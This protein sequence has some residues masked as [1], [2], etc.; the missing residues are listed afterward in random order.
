VAKE[1][2][3]APRSVAPVA[4]QELPLLLLVDDSE[5][6]LSLERAALGGTYRR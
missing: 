2:S 1:R 5:A 3:R 6:I 4:R